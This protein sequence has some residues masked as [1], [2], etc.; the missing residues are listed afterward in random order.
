MPRLARELA[1]LFARDSG[2]VQPLGRGPDARAGAPARA[3][4]ADAAR[5]GRYALDPSSPPAIGACSTIPRS[6]ARCARCMLALP[7]LRVLREAMATIDYASLF[8]AREFV[9]AELARAHRDRFAVIARE[10]AG[11][12]PYRIERAAIDRRRLRNTALRHLATL[13]IPP[14]SARRSNSSSAPTT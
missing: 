3:S 11:D 13:E 7:N 4:A 1:F 12:R 14:G 9:I 8:A 6:T 2:S 10:R 5:A